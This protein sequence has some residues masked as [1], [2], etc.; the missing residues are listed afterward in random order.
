MF[1]T[2]F[3]GHVPAWWCYMEAASY[4]IYRVLDEMDGK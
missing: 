4:F 1:G 2:D 3:Y